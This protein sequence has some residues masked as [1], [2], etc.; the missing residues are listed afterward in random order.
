M[1]FHPV[2]KLSAG[3]G[4]AESAIIHGDNKKALAL[5]ARQYSGKTRCAYIDP[6]YNN[7]E[8]YTHYSDVQRHDDWLEDVVSCARLI[9]P[10]LRSDGSLWVSIDDRQ[11]HYLK[12]ALDEVEPLPPTAENTW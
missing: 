3:K 6:P 2:K 5:L 4:A 7:Q 8:Q 9:K 10:L 11:V 12:V 1:A